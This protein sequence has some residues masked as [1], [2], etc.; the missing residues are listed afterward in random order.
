MPEP[1]KET[2]EVLDLLNTVVETIQKTLSSRIDHLCKVIEKLD[3]SIE[4]LKEADDA[5][6]KETS[7]LAETINKLEQNI[8]H[9]PC[10]VMVEHIKEHSRV[11]QA[12]HE[13]SIIRKKFIANVLTIVVAAVILGALG[14][15]W[16]AF[17]HGYNPT[18]K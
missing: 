6:G 1:T 14:A 8:H 11:E 5:R 9:P 18:G 7:D 16:Y 10:D 15:I 3:T 2:N 17:V 12:K 4:N 13:T